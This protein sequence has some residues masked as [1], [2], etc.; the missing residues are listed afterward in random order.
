[1]ELPNASEIRK[2]I[3]TIKDTPKPR[4]IK[5]KHVFKYVQYIGGY[6]IIF[7]TRDDNEPRT[8]IPS[9]VSIEQDT[10]AL[11]LNFVI[12]IL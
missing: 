10:H 5:S 3:D 11:M 12:L 9:V 8:P 2:T 4:R 1:M 7:S 6:P